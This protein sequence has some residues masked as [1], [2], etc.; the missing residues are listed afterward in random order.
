VKEGKGMG[1]EGEGEELREGER[2]GWGMGGQGRG[3]VAYSF[4][5]GMDAPVVTAWPIVQVRPI[6]EIQLLRWSVLNSCPV[7]DCR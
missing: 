6:Y 5:G 4:L 2:G 3:N 7:C 1:G